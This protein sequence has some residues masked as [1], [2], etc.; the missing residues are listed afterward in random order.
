MKVGYVRVSSVLQ[1]AGRQYEILKE[2]GIDKLFE[3][4]TSGKDCNRPVLNDMLDYVREGDTVYVTD[5]SRLAR[6]VKDL[7][8]IVEKL[9]AKNVNLIS[10]KEGFDLDTPQGKLQLTI[11]GAIYEFEREM[12]RERQLEGI[13]LAKLKGKYKGRKRIQEPANMEHVVLKWL[14]K[15]ITTTKAVEE[16]GLSKSTFYRMSKKYKERLDKT[17]KSDTL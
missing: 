14:N 3:E 6:N 5:Y 16:L 11:L 7:L 10:I 13:A 2:N 1:N 12:I 8:D 4:K 15:E 9:K 17:V